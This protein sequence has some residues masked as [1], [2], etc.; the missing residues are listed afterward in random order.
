[1]GSGRLRVLLDTHA[2]MFLW[3][4]HVKKFGRSSRNL[5]ERAHL[6]VSPMVRLELAF[7]REIGRIDPTPERVLT[8]LTHDVGLT[9]TDEPLDA[10]VLLAEPLT[11]TRDPFD[12]L[13]IASAMLHEL[14]F[15]T[16]DRDIQ[17]NFDAAVW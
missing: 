6:L 1:M 13:L 3:S 14:P 7:L 9:L 2:V 8:D 12:R 10:L 17:E 15:V 5:L 16:R 11:W 4:G